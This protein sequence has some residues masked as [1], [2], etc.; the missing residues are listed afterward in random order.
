MDDVRSV[1]GKETRTRSLYLEAIVDGVLLVVPE[2][3]ATLRSFQPGNARR[4]RRFGGKPKQARAH[5]QPFETRQSQVEA[6]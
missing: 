3:E 1:N 5:Y 4:F 2:L 6:S